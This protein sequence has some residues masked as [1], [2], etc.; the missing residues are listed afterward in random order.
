[1]DKDVT[2]KRLNFFK[3]FLTT[4]Q[5]WN[6]GESYHIQKRM[7]HNKTLHAPGV[8]RHFMGGLQVT[9]R[10]RGDLSVVVAPGYAVDGRG[11]DLYLSQPTIKQINPQDF[12]LP[13]EVYVVL[14]YEEEPS[15]FV[16][17][18]ENPLFKGHRRISEFVKV[19]VIPTEP[20]IEEEVEL[21]RISLQPDVRQIR[22]A[23]DPRNPKHNEIDLR[24][25]PIAGVAGSFLSAMQKQE[26]HE[27][28]RDQITIYSLAGHFLK[29]AT[30][31]DVLHALI[32]LDF[33]LS[34]NAINLGNFFEIFQSI[35]GL[36]KSMFGDVEQNHPEI[37]KEK[38]S[39][40][41]RYIE[42]ITLQYREPREAWKHVLYNESLAGKQLKILLPKQ[43]QEKVQADD[44]ETLL[45]R[46]KK[47]SEKF[48]KVLV[49]GSYKLQLI[50]TLDIYN[51]ESEKAHEFTIVN[52]QEKYRSRQ[53]L[54][55]QDNTEVV[56]VGVHYV[57]GYAQW[58]ILNVKPGKRVI[59]IRRVDVVRGNFYCDIQVN[60]KNAGELV[61]DDS[62]INLRWRN[63]PI[64]IPAKLVD[65]PT[66]TYRETPTKAD[67]DV[68][69]FRVWVYQEQ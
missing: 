61:V 33:L 29:I 47:R 1:M 45:E 18:K 24:F 16:A 59:M 69:V 38:F 27:F 9:Q 26:L 67:R 3:G 8:V 14:R 25:V 48:P 19:D 40:Y 43:K 68:N 4:E 36:Q 21:A 49:L 5:D 53:R 62:D 35:I 63:W 17:Y 20:D 22:D 46:V 60:G 31:L 11:R 55:Y 57:G 50:D 32:T 44:L 6:D 58:K 64:V 54:K 42:G 34:V 12:K 37:D 56:D 28:L 7:L 51:P 23:S 2:F 13:A 66:L 52:P 15:D 30:A 41:R 10:D 39:L 65:A